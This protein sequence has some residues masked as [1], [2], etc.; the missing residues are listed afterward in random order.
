MGMYKEKLSFDVAG[1]EGDVVASFIKG[2]DATIIDSTLTD[3]DTKSA[4]N[5]WV[6]NAIDVDLDYTTD[7]VTAYQGTSPWVVSGT[8][9]I[10]NWIST[11]E[12]TQGTDPWKV[13]DQ[14]C[15]TG[16]KITSQNITDTE[17]EIAAT[18]LTGRSRILVQNVGADT[19][20]LK[21]ATGVSTADFRLYKNEVLE[22]PIGASLNLFA[23]CA[24]GKTATLKIWELAA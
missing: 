10:G 17:S 20:Y 12:V 4:L 1:D 21:E 3:S 5:V 8:V 13:A 22:L 9:D 23:I 15:N 14:G 19:V 18:P 11:I 7:S 6:K 2:K 24:T 16:H